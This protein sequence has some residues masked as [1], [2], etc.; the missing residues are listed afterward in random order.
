MED[1]AVTHA[2]E[3][4]NELIH[5]KGCP[6]NPARIETITQK[7]PVSGAPI[8]I[9]RCIDCGAHVVLDATGNY[10]ETEN[11]APL[12]LGENGERPASGKKRA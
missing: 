1:I 4:S 9:A 3:A 11:S 7:A 2:Q 8:T 6:V 10:F 5:R 12:E